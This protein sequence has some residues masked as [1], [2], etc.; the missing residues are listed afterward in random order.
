MILS[1][2]PGKIKKIINVDLERPREKTNAKRLPIEKEILSEFK[3]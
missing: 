1:Y 3:L 2:R